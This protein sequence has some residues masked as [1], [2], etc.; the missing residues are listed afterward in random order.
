MRRII[1]IAA[2]PAGAACAAQIKHRLPEHEINLVIPSAVTAKAEAAG[3]AGRRFAAALP[4]TQAMAQRE[5]GVLETDDIMPDLEAGEISIGSSRGSLTVRYSDLVLEVPAT[6]RLPRP[7]QKANNVFTW[8]MPGFAASPEACD[9]A[10][11]DAA[12]TDRPVLVAGDGAAALE[13]VF[14][15]R[16]AGAAVRWLRT[17]SP[18]SPALEEQL[19]GVAL[20]RLDKVGGK[21]AVTAAP[22]LAAEE[23]VFDLEQNGAKLAGVSLP[24][25]EK[26]ACACSFWTGPLMARHPVLREDGVLLDH[27][28]RIIISDAARCPGL[29]LMGSGAALEDGSL[30]F[31]GARLPAFAGGDEQ[32]WSSAFAAIDDVSGKKSPRPPLLA[33]R[34]ARGAGLVFC[35]A[36]LSL[37]EAQAAG[38]DCEYAC[39]ALPEVE[40]QSAGTSAGRDKGPLL[41]LALVCDRASRT[42]LGAQVLG[43]HPFE[44]LA[45]PQDAGQDEKA[46]VQKLANQ[47]T[48]S[49][50]AMAD[51]LFALAG[52]A[53][54]GGVSVDLLARSCPAGAPANLLSRTAEVLVNKFDTIIKGISPAEFMASHQA[55]AEFFT[56]DLRSLPDWRLGHVPDAYNIPLSQLKKR[57]QDEVPRFTA[58]VTVSAFGRDAYIAASRMAALGAKDLYVLDGGMALWPYEDE[59][60]DLNNK[61]KPLLP[62][63]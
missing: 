31:S 4:D 49:I 40:L 21:V 6:V 51:G 20:K 22:D 9:A 53:L 2:G 42:L 61:M 39:L 14:L 56:L 45:G 38:L 19:L 18:E 30:P 50:E 8:P 54:A 12:K 10:L 44:D 57:I 46:K 26:I 5:I 32:A 55:G 16:E 36:G 23:L 43:A 35:R 52:A 62:Q 3:P 25:G 29:R 13:A 15:A 59:R 28:G 60:S 47:E 1:I 17:K 48:S 58:I 24:D 41:A 27:K 37:A 34:E 33:R 63:P 7:L 11:A